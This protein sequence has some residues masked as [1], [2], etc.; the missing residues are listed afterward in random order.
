ML[1]II[2]WVQGQTEDERGCSDQNGL[3][4]S[5]NRLEVDQPLELIQ[6]PPEESNHDM[7][8]T[9]QCVIQ[10]IVT[11][12]RINQQD[13]SKLIVRL[14]SLIPLHSCLPLWINSNYKQFIYSLPH[15]LNM[16]QR[17]MRTLW[18]LLIWIGRYS[19]RKKR[20]SMELPEVQCWVQFLWL[21]CAKIY[22]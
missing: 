13:W 3:E 8:P 18:S 4:C 22:L 2:S 7:P 9:M 12:Q 17:W 6:R 11:I 14:E 16:R 10:T 21:W 5:I 1:F 15:M 20:K 19:S